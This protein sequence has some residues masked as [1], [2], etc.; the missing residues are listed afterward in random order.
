MSIVLSKLFE[1]ILLSLLLPELE[2]R[3]LPSVIQTAYQHEV[4]CE[5]ATFSVYETVGHF[6]PVL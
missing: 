1:S 4:S 2:D 3:G 5:D 6:V